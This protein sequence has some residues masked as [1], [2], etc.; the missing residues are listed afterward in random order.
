MPKLHLPCS[1]VQ[2]G[3]HEWSVCI[4]NDNDHECKPDQKKI[5]VNLKACKTQTDV[6]IAF[7]HEFRHAMQFEYGLHDALDDN[8]LEMDAE[9]FGQQMAHTLP[10]LKHIK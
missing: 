1:K 8:L 5:S 9:I 3:L 2:V 10:K 6:L 4:D 7:F